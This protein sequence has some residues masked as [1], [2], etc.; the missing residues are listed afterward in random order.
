MFIVKVNYPSFFLLFFSGAAAAPCSFR[1]MLAR[2]PAEKQKK[3]WSVRF[4]I[5]MAPRWGFGPPENNRTDKIL[6]KMWAMLKPK[7][8]VSA[9]AILLGICITWLGF[10]TPARGAQPARDYP[11]KPVPF[12]AVHCDDIF[13][14]PRI[15][16]NRL[17]TIPFAFDQCEK[18]GRMDNFYRTA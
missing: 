9:L 7:G 16:T 1:S 6:P 17:V 5:N 8:R 12:T 10:A 13:W 11:V 15:E 2:R 18:Y 4:P 3:R 14:A